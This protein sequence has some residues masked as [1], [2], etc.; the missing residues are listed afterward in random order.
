MRTGSAPTR[1]IS[2]LG[3]GWR[4]VA[5]AGL[6]MVIV[7]YVLRGAL[8]V[9]PF[10]LPDAADRNYARM[11]VPQGWAFFT[12]DP[13]TARLSVVE[14]HDGQWR[15]VTPGRLAVPE[16]LMGLDR[17]RQARTS[18]LHLL[19]AAV[20]DSAWSECEAGPTDC[21]TRLPGGPA[22]AN[23]S[24]R[25]DVCGDIGLISQEVVPWAWRNMST[26]MPSRVAR[27]TVIC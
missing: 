9:T 10:S 18:D 19:V 12:G 7:L 25:R 1:E 13:R 24:Q 4:V 15:D 2:D 6:A 20:P 22:V 14:F 23:P 5:L 21:L 3:L 8:P 26:V 27:V 17:V 16:D 11:F